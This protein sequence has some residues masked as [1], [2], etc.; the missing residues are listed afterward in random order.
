MA[1]EIVYVGLRFFSFLAFFSKSEKPD[2]FTFFE[3]L[4]TFSRTLKDV[5]CY[6]MNSV[7][8]QVHN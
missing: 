3:L 8:N 1:S 6:C 2:F 7:A 4:H 5:L